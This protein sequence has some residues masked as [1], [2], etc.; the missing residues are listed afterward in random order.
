VTQHTSLL[1]DI[2]GAALKNI[3]RLYLDGGFAIVP[4]QFGIVC[5]WD[6]LNILATSTAICPFEGLESTFI[7]VKAHIQATDVVVTDAFIRTRTLT[8]DGVSTDSLWL[9]YNISGIAGSK[10]YVTLMETTFNT[11]EQEPIWK[12]NTD[13]T[14]SCDPDS[15]NFWDSAFY[16]RDTVKYVRT[17]IVQTDT[18]VVT[19]VA[20]AS[21]S[22][23]SHYSKINAI[24]PRTYILDSESDYIQFDLMLDKNECDDST[25][26]TMKI[27]IQ[28]TPPE[29]TL[30]PLPSRLEAYE[31]TGVET[32]ETHVPDCNCK[33]SIWPIDECN[34]CVLN[35]M[36]GSSPAQRTKLCTTDQNFI[37]ISRF[38]YS[39]YKQSRIIRLDE[40][41]RA[42]VKLKQTSEINGLKF[43][44]LSIRG[45]IPPI[46]EGCLDSATC[47]GAVETCTATW[48]QTTCQTTCPVDRRIYFFTFSPSV[49]LGEIIQQDATGTKDALQLN[50]EFD[51][52][53][54]IYVTQ[55]VEKLQEVQVTTSGFTTWNRVFNAH[56]TKSTVI[57][58]DYPEIDFC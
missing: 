37:S 36:V 16:C 58:R 12:T 11:C 39:M 44:H 15:S 45:V 49:M 27:R 1:N 18:L 10:T 38:F 48:S 23:V 55:R 24:V 41:T 4:K 53:G 52:G 46:C 33:Q 13:G 28:K 34:Q 19:Y 25:L 3:H 32:C 9:R 40:N 43:A 29:T 50:F 54:K 14:L 6:P 8:E 57:M 56:D 2:P 26:S 17:P 42:V 22:G 21:Q 5:P 47:Q 30:L 35:G 20:S 51:I 7:D 31:G